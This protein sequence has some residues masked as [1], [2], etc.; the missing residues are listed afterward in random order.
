MKAGGHSPY[1]SPPFGH[2]CLLLALQ[3][4]HFLSCCQEARAVP[5]GWKVLPHS[6]L[7]SS[8]F[9][10]A[11]VEVFSTKRSLSEETSGHSADPHHSGS[12]RPAVS[13]VCAWFSPGDCEYL[14]GNNPV[15]FP[16][17]SAFSK[18]PGRHTLKMG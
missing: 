11:L 1:C 10:D 2:T 14:E 13:G 16:C 8:S 15:P 3:N 18:A 5:Y 17:I 12:D 7:K 4:C 9:F 6:S